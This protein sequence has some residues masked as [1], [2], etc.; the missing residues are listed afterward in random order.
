MNTISAIGVALHEASQPDFKVYAQQV[1][2][3]AKAMADEF[4]TL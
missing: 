2:A 4:L 1:V 3:N